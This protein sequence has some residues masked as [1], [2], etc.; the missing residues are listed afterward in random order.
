HQNF[1]DDLESFLHVPTWTSVRYC[2]SNLT[3]QE[4]T[5]Y[6][7]TTFDE[8]D[9][10]NGVCVG[11]LVKSGVR[12]QPRPPEKAF[13]NYYELKTRFDL[14]DPFWI[15]QMEDNVVHRYLKRMEILKNSIWFSSTIRQYL[16]NPELK[17]PI[18]DKAHRLPLASKIG[19]TETQKMR[20]S[21]RIDSEDLA[22]SDS[23]FPRESNHSTKRKSSYPPAEKESFSKRRKRA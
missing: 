2:P 23:H 17:W 6:L 8:V 16:A 10:K 3:A 5:T 7:R 21:N 4:R 1:E 18:R 12:Y 14:A 11:G 20:D 9:E 19:A 13:K 22:H 15:D